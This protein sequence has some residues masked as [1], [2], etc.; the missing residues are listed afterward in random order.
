MK[1]REKGIYKKVYKYVLMAAICGLNC[2]AQAASVLDALN[3]HLITNRKLHQKYE[4][5]S[6]KCSK[7][8]G[9]LKVAKMFGAGLVNSNINSKIGY[10]SEDCETSKKY[11]VGHKK[12][13]EAIEPAHAF[14]A[15]IEK[16]YQDYLK[17]GHNGEIK[18]TE[19]SE[20]MRQVY[21][22]T[23]KDGRTFTDFVIQTHRLNE[24]GMDGL[25]DK[26]WPVGGYLQKIGYY[27]S[28]QFRGSLSHFSSLND[29]RDAASA[30]SHAL[31]VDVATLANCQEKDTLP[32]EYNFRFRPFQEYLDSIRGWTH[33][34]GGD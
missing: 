22:K 29:E 26:G 11:Y 13:V 5:M 25:V 2:Q 12:A 34:I 15:E 28:S 7:K 24:E 4:E 27:L 30:R 31:S 33:G 17:T 20:T 21:S 18:V 10:Y 8:A 6:Q 32:K 1:D 23:V 9:K 14:L 3:V 16:A 19:Y